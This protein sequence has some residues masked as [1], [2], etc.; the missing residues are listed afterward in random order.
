MLPTQNIQ[1][2]GYVEKAAICR[3]P[4]YQDMYRRPYSMNISQD[5]ASVIGN[6]S[7]GVD[8][9]RERLAPIAASVIAPQTYVESVCNVPEGWGSERCL[10]IL[11]IVHGR[12]GDQ[13]LNKRVQ[14]LTG[15]TSHMGMMPSQMRANDVVVDDNMRLF[16]N[17][18]MLFNETSHIDGYG[19]KLVTAMPLMAS[20]LVMGQHGGVH[21]HND[22]TLRPEDVYS[23][24]NVGQLIQQNNQYD[25]S[26]G[27]NG[28]IGQLYD[29]RTAFQPGQPYKLS[30]LNNLVP[31]NYLSKVLTGAAT[32]QLTL[33]GQRANPA[34]TSN[35]IATGLNEGYLSNDL[36][37]QHILDRTGLRENCS[38]TFGELR[39]ILPNI[40]APGILT[41]AGME[42]VGTGQ[43]AGAVG[44]AGSEHHQGS[45]Y[46]TVI[47]NMLNNVTTALMMDLMIG[48][49]HCNGGNMTVADVATGT[50][51][52]Q[53]LLNTPYATSFVDGRDAVALCES[54]KLRLVREFLSSFTGHN[55]VPIGFAIHASLMAE[56]VIDV[57]YNNQPKIRFVFPV[58]ANASYTPIIT[59]D[60]NT[61]N[62]IAV[63]TRELVQQLTNVF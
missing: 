39:R 53:F 8:Y 47:A 18:S 36:T 59:G 4:A 21:G 30:Q 17:T 31:S 32:E 49:I 55:H 11:K 60:Q 24:I 33:G 22:R 61:L 51:S 25:Q 40:D 16:F 58:F 57:S 15:Y 35:Q 41:K 27:T 10:F 44:G 43:V 5:T 34:D 37:L 52:G 54:F 3:T 2:E 13:G 23:A 6:M 50:M 46:E 42:G 7:A 45:N 9:S 28:P 14:Y 12:P 19:R 48:E 56:T 38:I 1:F 29:G 63:H 62:S 26:R 20:Q